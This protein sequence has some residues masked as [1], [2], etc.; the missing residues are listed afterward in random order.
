M[1]LQD[2]FGLVAWTWQRCNYLLLLMSLLAMQ[3]KADLETPK[4]KH[5]T[6]KTGQ[7]GRCM[8]DDC[9]PGGIQSRTVWCIHSEGW[10]THHS[11]CKH[12]NKPD[13]QRECFKVCEWHQELF[14]WEVSEWGPCV[15]VPY[16][17][18]DQKLRTS[19]CVTAQH[20]LQQRE[21]HCFRKS[22]KTAV[23]NEICEFFSSRPTTEQACLIPCPHNC[24]VSKFSAWSGCSKTCG[25]GLQHRTRAVLAPPLYGG[26]N[27]PNLTE[28]RTCKNHLPCS[29]GDDEYEYSL[30][31]GPW[32][33]CRL[34]HQKDVWLSGRTM[35]DFSTESAE[36]NIVKHQFQ[37]HHNNAHPKEWD[38]EIGYQA[39]QVR[40]MRSDGKNAML[41]LCIQ[42]NAP[43]TIQSCVMPR[44]CET[45]DWS[46]WSPCS[47]TCQ[48][49]DLSPGYRTRTRTLKQIPLGG[50][51]ECPALEE[52]EACNIVG[53]FLPQCPRFVWKTTE[54]EECQMAPLLSP[55]DRRQ[56]NHSMLCG[57][58]IQMRERY[59]VQSPD[60]PRTSHKEVSRPVNGKL[61]SG[62]TPSVAQMCSVPCAQLCLLSSWS[63]WGPCT[64]ENC[65]D[66]QGR[67][68]F[69]FR[70]RRVIQEPTGISDSCPHL[71][72]FI[73]C[74]DPICYQ[75]HVT[76]K[77]PC[78]PNKDTCGQGT[79]KQNVVC[80]D[81]EGKSVSDDHC[82]DE[83]PS[84]RLPCDVPC[85]LD[86]VI[87]DWSPWSSCSHSCSSKNAEG[88]QSRVRSVVAQPGQDGKPCPSAQALEEWRQCNDHPCTVF[89]WDVSPWGPCT[90]D[91]SMT[92]INA[93]S[94]WNGKPTC[95]VGIQTRKVICMK[96]NVGQVTPKRCPDSARPDTIR[97]CLLPCKKDC[98]VTAFSE[99]TPCPTVCQPV[100]STSKQFRYR[101]IIQRP[102]S[103]GEECPDTLYEERECEALPPCPVYRWKTQKWNP[104]MIV[105]ESVRHRITGLS[106]SCGL[107]LESRDVTCV[108]D[109]DV[110]ADITYCLQWAGPMPSVVKEC[111]E[112]CRDDCTFTT[113]SKFTSCMGCGAMRIRK[114]SLT[115]K[116]RKREKCQNLEL[117]PQTEMEPCPCDEFISQP[118]GN[119]SDCILPE[120]K[121][122]LQLGIRV[123]GDIKECGQGT[124]YRS[125]VCYGPNERIVDPLFCS[126]SGYIEE[127]CTVPCP[128]DCKLSEWSSWSTCSSPCGSGVK[129]RSKWLREKPFNGG[130]PCPKL[131]VKNQV[132]EAIPCYSECSQ[133]I[134]V[135]EP[136]SSCTINSIDKVPDCGEGVQSR[137]VKC[138]NITNEGPSIIVDDALCDQE[139][140]PLR[141]QTCFFPCPEDCAMSNWG[142]WSICP[143][144]CDSKDV[145]RRVRHTLRLSVSGN[146]CPQDSET[147]PC[148][149]NSNC[150]TYQYN[151]TDW[152]SCQLSDN[153]VCGQ[154]TR[155]RLLDCIRSDGKPVELKYCEELELEKKWTLTIHC[156]VE[157]PVN[158]QLS[159]WST[160][161]ECS[162]SCG[163]QGQM[164]RSRSIDQ[165]S[166]GEGRPCPSQLTQV[167]PCPVKPCYTWILGDWSKCRVE[168]AQ[169]G[170]GVRRRNLTC[171][172]HSGLDSD[173]PSAKPVKEEQCE[174]NLMKFNSREL[175]QP[176]SV[177]CPGDCHLTEWSS[178][179]S[180][181]LTCLDGRSFE[182]IGRQARSRA[183]IIQA[184]E[185]QDNCPQQVFE[186]RPCTDGK[187]HTY[188]W[189]TS[190]WRDNERSVW[191]QRSD[192]VNVTGGCFLQNQPET[193]RHC[194]PPC[195]KPFSHCTQNG[196]CGCDK[197]YIEVMTV[198]GFLD[199]CTK[200]PGSDNKKA[201]V[202]TSVGKF[203][204]G[205]S[206][207]QDFFRDWPFHP[208]GPDGRIKI[209]VYGVT[210][211]GFLLIIFI[212]AMSF[213][214]CK[215]PKQQKSAAPQQ[216]PL[217]LG[218]DGD[219]DM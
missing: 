141:A 88:K 96:M 38:L 82:L 120:N 206:Q 194:H 205:T 140:M 219:M 151:V 209:W 42:D 195:T 94:N 150:F 218:Y 199:Y 183:V 107:G 132:Y 85:P 176:C 161:T 138:T 181:Q 60:D 91:I 1:I 113:W 22:N 47:K 139:E 18:Y 122:E 66:P 155:T 163:L 118:Y 58:G 11:N 8:G 97:P 148:V 43:V 109:G 142:P 63:A 111:R 70:R 108:S 100:N 89:F 175:E 7:W 153:A 99:W 162:K 201:D 95:A 177:P 50:G 55:F 68:G 35:L 208:F 216:K 211:C 64:Y 61:C 179:S 117:F 146:L 102:A 189:K 115:G 37:S 44:Q 49:V 112:P 178:W 10:T 185:N 114:R 15:L 32:S 110:P 20:G 75:W 210:V 12:L 124:R 190:P 93:T 127:S 171:V 81:I 174:T 129:V 128:F 77:H 164:T 106:E 62:P 157:C 76:E 21:V 90:E 13:S 144:P 168:G 186:T 40:C 123:P 105:P 136:W 182:T 26:V 217:T 23:A 54:W 116:S 166:H 212:I 45:S 24:V 197:G 31:V 204:P 4:E 214:A 213:L 41:T 59:C 65:Q 27:C 134:W 145:R 87:S 130:R 16:L 135:T 154:G 170:E 152:S 147:E 184:F 83:P 104:C 137:K 158:C 203:K 69:R 191:C 172:V 36:K 25:A 78:E 126:S 29:I 187:C 133:N 169:C 198:Y 188:E 160:W 192:G 156:L 86:C 73:P 131:D 92:T 149:L 121:A 84:S 9:G 79:Q 143:Q 17:A 215:T 28:T 72:E 207:I 57:G 19:E 125:V 14:K 165:Q 71:V 103:G 46:S 39:R 56:N 80:K 74:E 159:E 193:V 101:I 196:V 200:I 202:K 167:K 173:F 34:P 5:Y 33:E 52:K 48:S 3:T 6:W 53:D 119:W 67:K 30:K 98:I 180:C 51:K 2:E